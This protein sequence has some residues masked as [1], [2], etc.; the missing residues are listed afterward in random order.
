[1][2]I[3]K[4]LNLVLKRVDYNTDSHVYRETL[5]KLSWFSEQSFDF[6]CSHQLEFVSGQVEII[7]TSGVQ[8]SYLVPRW[9][10]DSFLLVISSFSIVD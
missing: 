5:Y 6:D 4:P 1:M 3:Q 7:K 8:T 10:C 2:I 9:A